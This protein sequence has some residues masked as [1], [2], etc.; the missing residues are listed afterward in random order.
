MNESEAEL[1]KT[2]AGH[3]EALDGYAV[4]RVSHRLDAEEMSCLVY[5]P[6]SSVQFTLCMK[7]R[8]TVENHKDNMQNV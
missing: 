8:F 5:A 1:N 7:H 3:L 4:I 6:H 2:Y